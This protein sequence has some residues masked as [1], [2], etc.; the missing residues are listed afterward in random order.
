M[1]QMKMFN[2]KTRKMMRQSM[3]SRLK[4]LVQRLIYY[5]Y[6]LFLSSFVVILSGIGLAEI[7]WMWY[8]RRISVCWSVSLPYACIKTTCYR[9]ARF[10]WLPCVADADIIFL[11]CFFFLFFR[12]LI[13]AVAEW[14]FTILRHMMSWCG[15]SANLECRPETCCTWL[16]GNAGPKN[17][18]KIT[19]WA[20]SYNFVGPYLRN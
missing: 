9:V 17:S 4:K 14:M 18:Q 5:L 3:S 2:K 16:A 10:L 7:R 12:R 19:I 8:C 15:P 6:L 13:S 1:T 11:S 20:P